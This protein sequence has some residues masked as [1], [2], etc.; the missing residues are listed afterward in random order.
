MEM[1]SIVKACMDLGIK[2]IKLTGGEPLIREDIVEIVETLSSLEP[3]DLA[4]TTNGYYLEE[5]AL[6]LKK[7]GLMRIN[8]SLPSLDK[9]VYETVTGVDGLDKVLR[10]LKKALDIGLKPVKVN[11]VIL[12]D[13]NEGEVWDMIKLASQM[14]FILQLIELEPVDMPS[15]LYRDLHADLDSIEREISSRGVLV[16]RRRYMHNRPQY[17]IGGAVVEIVKPVH[18]PDFCLHCTRIRVSSDGKLYTCL[19]DSSNHFDLNKA[20]ESNDPVENIKEIIIKA[21]RA[22]KPYFMSRCDIHG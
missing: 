3:E 19:M 18:N 20:L 14:K 2:K 12:K 11:M 4:I 13:I 10:G 7:A 15:Y 16:N 22:R 17:R 9:K 8:V 5:L 6:P 1:R 21:N